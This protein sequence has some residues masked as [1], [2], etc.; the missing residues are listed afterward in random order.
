MLDLSVIL[1]FPPTVRPV[2]RD[3]M[4]SLIL[5][6]FDFT[7][8][9]VSD[10][11]LASQEHIQALQA[12]LNEAD[13]EPALIAVLLDQALG[14]GPA[15]TRLVHKYAPAFRHICF[16][17]PIIAPVELETLPLSLEDADMIRTTLAD[18]IPGTQTLSA[19]NDGI[20]I[21]PP[22]GQEFDQE[23]F[24]LIRGYLAQH[25][26]VPPS[27]DPLF[28]P[29]G[30]NRLKEGICGIRLLMPTEGVP[31]LC[32]DRFRRERPDTKWF[33]LVGEE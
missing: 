23:T 13:L 28:T 19:L 21:L 4:Q 12:L 32:F 9:Q 26:L 3:A 15:I 1:G 22:E 27:L 7:P 18:E 8:A 20:D 33:L 17:C 31:R 5:D 14:N 29:A 2:V 30:Y 16:D 10:L 25:D 6:V 11:G 24:E